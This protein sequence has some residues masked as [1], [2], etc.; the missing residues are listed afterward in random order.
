M[1]QQTAGAAVR[2]RKGKPQGQWSVDGKDPLNHSEEL[3]QEDDGL[4]VKQRIID[5]YSKQGFGA[6]THDDLFQRMKWAGVYTQRRQG[7][8]GH[9]TGQISDMELADEYFMMRIRI[10]GGALTTEQLRVIA[11]ISNEFGRGTADITDRQNIQ[12]HWV[13]VEDLSLIHI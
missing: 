7:I 8:E 13:R 11:D 6:I 9:R 5:V 4:N 10:D 2:P 1:T 3:K 12:L